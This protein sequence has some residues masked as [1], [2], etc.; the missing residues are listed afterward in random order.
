M[1]SFA[2]HLRRLSAPELPPY[3]RLSNLRSC[4][5]HFAPYGFR[6]TY[7]YLT[8]SA[9]I[10]RSL[11]ADPESLVRAAGE[12]HEA[13]TMWLVGIQPLK[14]QRREAKLQG[15]RALPDASWWNSYGNV[16]TYSPDPC[17]YPDL[18]LAAFVRRQLDRASGADMVGC[19]SC[20]DEREPASYSTGHGFI[21]RCRQC[22]ILIRPCRCGAR[23]Q[24]E[25]S[26]LEGL[27]PGIWER[28]HMGDDGRPNPRWPGW[29]NL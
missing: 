23:H 10:P 6:S 15:N 8:I 18:T 28:R 13:R 20:G 26:R 1:S 29:T 21:D 5:L 22:G 25:V 4:I 14:Q 24:E 11:E 3:R 16:L 9:R 2:T 12:L 27:R 7:F 17:R 19:P